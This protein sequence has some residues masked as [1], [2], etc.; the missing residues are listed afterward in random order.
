MEVVPTE[1]IVEEEPLTEPVIGTSYD[2]RI[3]DFSTTTGTTAPLAVWYFS[4]Y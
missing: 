1:P 3:G 4:L 2:L